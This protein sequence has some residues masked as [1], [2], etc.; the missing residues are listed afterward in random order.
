MTALLPFQMRLFFMKKH[1]FPVIMGLVSLI[2]FVAAMAGFDFTTASEYAAQF[3]RQQALQV[4][5]ATNAIEDQLDMISA[6][7]ASLAGHARFAIDYGATY[8]A[9]LL[10]AHIT[11]QPNILAYVLMDTPHSLKSVELASVPL[12]ME[13]AAY[14]QEWITQNWSNAPEQ[15]AGN[16]LKAPL[17]I[18]PEHQLAGLLYP[19]SDGK[20]L[21]GMSATVVSLTR[22][23]K[24]YVADLHVDNIGQGYLLADDGT[25]LFDPDSN[26]IGKN[27]FTHIYENAPERMHVFREVLAARSGSGIFDF[28]DTENSKAQQMLLAWDTV[29]FAGRRLKV[30]LAVSGDTVNEVMQR[31]ARWRIAAG[32]L[33]LVGLVLASTLIIYRSGLAKVRENEERLQMALTGNQDGLWD[34]NIPDGRVYY[35][36]RWKEIMGLETDQQLSSPEEW[37]SRIHRAD[38]EEVTA[39]LQE[40]LRGGV[41]YFQTEHRAVRADGAVIWVLERGA[42]ISHDREGKPARLVGTTTD[43]TARR[44]AMMERDMLFRNSIDLLAI[45]D[46]EGNILEA[47]PAWENMLGW[48]AEELRLPPC[49]DYVHPDDV[50][51]AA[52]NFALLMKGIPVRAHE[53]RFLKKEGSWIWLSW[54]VLPDMQPRRIYVTAR[55]ISR[56]KAHERRLHEQA[57][58]DE[59]TGIFNRRRVLDIGKAEMARSRRFGRPLACLMIDIDHFKQINDTYGHVAGDA[60][61]RGVTATLSAG[62]RQSDTLGRLGG[63]EF[64]VFMPETDAE[65]AMHTAE[66]LR[67]AVEQSSVLMDGEG[68]SPGITVSLGVTVLAPETASLDAFIAAADAALY[69]AKE[70]G[71]NRVEFQ[72]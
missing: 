50:P 47:N 48:T 69:R 6:S 55:D 36:P 49:F 44:Q 16:L 52:E 30:C 68:A 33:F 13:A 26:N 72:K 21:L 23:I 31:Q 1:F 45:T 43:V 65:G 67:Q 66:R 60:V 40:H 59:L 22:I 35:S 46:V 18:T 15:L 29:D 10:S 62:L 5:V 9:K 24:R 17:H 70:N 19:F 12:S 28:P 14:A 64:I 42:V 38:K 61:L 39:H 41:P 11:R 57:S 4:R 34:W 32:V 37:S 8:Q 25:L 51:K 58:T 27:I 53:G 20:K 71:R 63:E 3:S 2:A 56:Q 54:N 7:G